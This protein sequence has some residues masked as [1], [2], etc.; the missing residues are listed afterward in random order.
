MTD[1]ESM[2]EKLYRCKACGYTAKTGAGLSGHI[3]LAHGER[4][5]GRAELEKIGAELVGIREDLNQGIGRLATDGG[6]AL[7]SFAE[8]LESSPAVEALIGELRELNAH[9]LSLQTSLDLHRPPPGT[10]SPQTRGTPRHSRDDLW[11]W[12]PPSPTMRPPAP[13]PLPAI[14][15]PPPPIGEM[16]GT[17]IVGGVVALGALAILNKVLNSDNQR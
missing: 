6:A 5:S 3:Q 17:L 1:Y 13:P 9:C 12:Q 14:L 11:E 4:A 7:G 10:Q 8:R 15:P 2:S 16:L